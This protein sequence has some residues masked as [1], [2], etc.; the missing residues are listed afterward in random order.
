[1]TGPEPAAIR[2]TLE[3]LRSPPGG[4]VFSFI[5]IL[6]SNLL[7]QSTPNGTIWILENLLFGHIGQSGVIIHI[8]KEKD[9]FDVKLRSKNV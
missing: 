1:M 7:S 9:A 6:E 8:S 5:C 2:S 4:Q 3:R